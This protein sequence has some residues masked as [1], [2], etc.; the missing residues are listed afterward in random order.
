MTSGKEI[1]SRIDSEQVRGLLLI[2]GGAAVT[3]IALI[4]YI[5]DKPEFLILSRGIFIAL[6]LFQLGLVF[7]VIHNR[8][9]RKCA[10]EYEDDEID[11]SNWPDPCRFLWW[12][13]H[14]PCICMRS[15]AFMWASVT[16][17]VLGGLVVA[18]SGFWALG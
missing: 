5:L 14:E 12:K 15:I 2:N 18:I 11:S 10:L 1:R 16:F 6:I 7:A 8:Q 4:P 17:F 9:R 13:T 3:L